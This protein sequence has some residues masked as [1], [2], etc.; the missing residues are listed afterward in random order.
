MQRLAILGLTLRTFVVM[1]YG[2]TRG[3]WPRGFLA[4]MAMAVLPKEFPVFLATFL[5]L[6]GWRRISSNRV[7]TCKISAVETLGATTVLCTDKTDTLTENHMA[8]KQLFAEGR[9]F[10]IDTQKDALANEVHNTVE[11]N[12]L[13]SQSETV[14]PNGGGVQETGR[15][16]PQEDG[17]HPQRLDYLGRVSSF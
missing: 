12:I 6:G 13:A 2:F 16:L 8:A 3:D 15:R 10:S 1:I 7:L 17:T 5:A 4:C 14:W 11:Y 9:F